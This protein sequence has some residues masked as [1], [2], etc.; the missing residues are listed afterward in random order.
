MKYIVGLL[1]CLF[2]TNQIAFGEENTKEEAY[3]E[4]VSGNLDNDFYMIYFDYNKN[5]PYLGLESLLNFLELDDLKVNLKSKTLEG[6][7][8]GLNEKSIIVEDSL[9][10]KDEFIKDDEI[11]IS[12]DDLKKI[13]PIENIIWDSDGLKLILDFKFKL[14]SQLRVEAE[15]RIRTL[16]NKNKNSEEINADIVVKH[17]IISPGIL[18]FEYNKQNIE[19]KEYNLNVAYGS[20]LFYGDFKISQEI[21][22]DSKLN[23]INLE[24]DDILKKN[25][26]LVLGDSYLQLDDYTD[27]ERNIRG[28]S[29]SK[30][31]LYTYANNNETVIQGEAYNAN[32]VEL[33]Q[34]GNLIDY[35]RISG[36]QNFSFKVSNLSNFT[37][38]IIKIY[39][40]N[41]KIE[42]RE[43]SILSTNDI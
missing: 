6:K 24:Y 42:T 17:K 22:P 13:F 23:Y 8:I 32:L 14:P 1:L 15:N 37:T 2:F 39:Y 40:N 43:V 36:K 31:N 29:I 16:E 33:L 20:Q 28:F 21:K 30:S 9:N 5:K 4:I 3:I 18:K 27:I 34:N 38:Y 10:F 25:N 12:L 26:K 11:Y 35:K 41:G 19:K 7:Y